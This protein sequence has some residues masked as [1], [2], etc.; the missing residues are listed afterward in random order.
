[1]RTVLVEL[2]L[3]DGDAMEVDRLRRSLREELLGLEVDRVATVA[4]AAPENAKGLGT[5]LGS[6]VVTL[7]NSAILLA[8]CQ[9][10]RAWV[11]HNKNRRVVIKDNDRTLELTAVSAAQHQ[12]IIAAFL[13]NAEPKAS[14]DHGADQ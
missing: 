13:R 8:V 1:M 6:L 14:E 12:E 9:T 4:A 5:E 2:T 7:A 3:V 10:I 11:M